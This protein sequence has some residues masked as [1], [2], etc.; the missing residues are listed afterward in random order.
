[1]GDAIVGIFNDADQSAIAVDK[2]IAR[3]VAETRISVLV[4]EDA[5][6]ESLGIDE[7]TKA[8][9][10]ATAG[11]AIGAAAGAIFGGLT[12]VGAIASGGALLVAGPL[13]AAAAGAGAGGVTGGLLGGLI[14][15]GFSE[16]EVKHFEEALDE[17]AALVAVDMDDYDDEDVV[18]DVLDN[19]GADEVS[20]A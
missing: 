9:E 19:S 14:G 11:G 1:M 16:H 4:T 17:G 2:L 15:A 10:G 18:E 12:A 5:A 8:P 13:V 6:R 7:A 3:G 20:S